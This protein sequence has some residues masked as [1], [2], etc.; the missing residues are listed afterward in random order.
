VSSY[1]ALYA[2]IL[3]PHPTHNSLGS[4]HILLL[5]LFLLLLSSSSFFLFLS[6]LSFFFLFLFLFSLSFLSS[7]SIILF[8]SFPGSKLPKLS[9]SCMRA[10]SHT[11]EKLRRMAPIK[12]LPYVGHNPLE[13]LPHV[14]NF[15]YTTREVS[16]KRTRKACCITP[17]ALGVNQVYLLGMQ[18]LHLST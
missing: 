3:N 17:V 8:F 4:S 14:L 13:S 15:F 1:L 10:C 12:N 16:T 6:L 11:C 2:L 18:C 7:F 5:L 9:L